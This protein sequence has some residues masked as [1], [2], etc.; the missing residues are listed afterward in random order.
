MAGVNRLSII[1]LVWITLTGFAVATLAQQGGEFKAMLSGKEQVPPIESNATGIAEIT[2]LEENSTGVVYYTV[3]ASNA[4]EVTS[5]HIHMGKQGENGP[6]VATL[7]KYDSPRNEA[8][9]NGYITADKLEGPMLGKQV[10]DLINAITN[11]ETYVNI[12][13][14]GHPNGEI[15]GQ[16]R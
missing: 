13:T 5:G 2:T 14:E 3:N 16:I 8:A 6:V 10:S 9:A 12:H 15:R 4:A 1:M 7:F 11:G